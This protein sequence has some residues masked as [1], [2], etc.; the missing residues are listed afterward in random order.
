MLRGVEGTVI[1]GG[2]TVGAG[3][4]KISAGLTIA[5]TTSQA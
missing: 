1:L 3:T 4:V 2:A 5:E